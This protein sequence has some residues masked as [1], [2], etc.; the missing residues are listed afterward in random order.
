MYKAQVQ[1]VKDLH[2]KPDRIIL[3][4]EKVGKTLECTGTREICLKRILMAYTLRCRIHKWNLKKLKSFCKMKD[5]VNGT[6]LSDLGYTQSSHEFGNTHYSHG[7]ILALHNLASSSVT[8]HVFEKSP[9]SLMEKSGIEMIK[10]EGSRT[11]QE[12]P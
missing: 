4:E 6:L 9:E 2:I 12:S 3:I 1:V 10:S 5:T 7:G 11:P 8:V